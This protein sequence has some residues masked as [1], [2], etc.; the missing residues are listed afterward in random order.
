MILFLPLSLVD[1]YLQSSWKF[2]IYWPSS[3]SMFWKFI[4][5]FKFVSILWKKKSS[6]FILKINIEIHSQVVL[7]WF[8][9]KTA[10]LVWVG[11]HWSPNLRL[12][13]IW[14]MNIA[15]ATTIY[16]VTIF[17]IF[18]FVWLINH[19]N[20]A[21]PKVMLFALLF[22]SHINFCSEKLKKFQSMH[23]NLKIEQHGHARWILSLI[24]S[25]Y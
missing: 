19:K 1:D 22:F 10:H 25:S 14:K 2:L 5:S 11:F 3:N 8:R 4:Q 16:S 20:V 17:I 15:A 12:L 13:A 9:V 7:A 23:W 18:H 6:L 21:P 24:K